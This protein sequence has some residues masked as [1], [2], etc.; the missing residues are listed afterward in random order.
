[1]TGAA[2][3]PDSRHRQR[4]SPTELV[5]SACRVAAFL[6]GILGLVCGRA[7]RHGAARALL[8]ELKTRSRSNYVPP[9]AMAA[10]YR[11]LGEANQALEWLDKGVEERD[12][13][14]LCA[15]KSEP[16]YIPLRGHPRYQALLRKMNL[17]P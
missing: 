6:L 9:H 1:V 4:S 10:V 5:V 7:G 8:E 15:L 11:G 3:C 12:L 13:L 16:G 17:E 2:R 14:V